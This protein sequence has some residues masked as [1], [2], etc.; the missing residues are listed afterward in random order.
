MLSL[1][2]DRFCVLWLPPFNA[3]TDPRC[4]SLNV[5]RAQAGQ[6][7]GVLD[8]I[9]WYVNRRRPACQT[10]RRSHVRVGSVDQIEP[11]REPT[12]PE[13]QPRTTI[14][15]LQRKGGCA[16]DGG[17]TLKRLLLLGGGHA[18]VEVM[19]DFGRAPPPD[20]HVTVLSRARFT[21]YSGMLPGLVAGHY[22]H[23]ESHI[24]LA[25]L[26]RS[27]GCDFVEAE[28]RHL[29][30]RERAVACTDDS[31]AGYDV[32]SID[33]GSTPAA[34]GVPGADS[35]TLA[36]KPVDAFLARWKTIEARV[37]AG[38]RLRIA[39]VGGGAGGVE[40]L[41]SLQDRL[42]AAVRG[43]TRFV[44]LTDQSDILLSH[45]RKVRGIFREVLASRKIELLVHHAVV[46][47]DPGRLHCANGETVEADVIVWVTT[48]AA[49][50][51]IAQSGL[52][53]DHRGFIAV[54]DCLQSASHKNVFAAGDIATM[55]NHALPKSGVYA[56]RQGPPLA[57]NLRRAVASERLAE[58][59]PQRLALALIGTGDRSAVASY[60]PF[61]ARGEWIWRW[62]E[63]IDRRWIGRYLP[64]GEAG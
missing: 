54:N 63:W 23:E 42:H 39:V 4:H 14:G 50:Q 11:A 64:P 36:I 20:T 26:A 16:H 59:T 29:D 44:L 27:T 62:K 60:G 47:V 58:Y 34:A 51:W 30:P 55:V 19:R 3:A 40:L 15:K 24:D 38:E 46:R 13:S 2:P 6:T 43:E 10:S 21:P 61:A 5:A 18:H 1:V 35:H 22:R 53:T 8:R 17:E 28:A 48:A 33:I 25:W 31:R 37:A 49:P 12:S 9:L 45:N 56:V 32:I 52:T 7:I 41:L 57:R